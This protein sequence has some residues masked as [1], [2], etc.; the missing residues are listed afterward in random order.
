MLSRME[1][2]QPTESSPRRVPTVRASPARR[3]W[4][5]AT[6]TRTI[7]HV[8]GTHQILVLAPALRTLSLDRLRRQRHDARP[9]RPAPN[10]SPRRITTTAAPAKTT[11]T[12]RSRARFWVLWTWRNATHPGRVH[13]SVSPM[14][15]SSI[16]AKSSGNPTRHRQPRDD[17]PDDGEREQEHRHLSSTVHLTTIRIADA[18]TFPSPCRG[19][20]AARDPRTAYSANRPI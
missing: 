12:R 9:E 10:A 14:R 13:S 3:R 5:P 19:R 8:D 7:R 1:A 11:Y 18:I 16:A 2:S 15:R 4:P 6:S 17:E 20:Q